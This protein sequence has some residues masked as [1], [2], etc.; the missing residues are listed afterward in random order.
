M[1]VA[2]IAEYLGVTRQRVHQLVPTPGFPAPVTEVVTREWDPAEIEAW[3]ARTWWDTKPWRE[4]PT[5]IH[6][7]RRISSR[8]VRREP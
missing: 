5:T 7:G 6:D 1:N 8:D 2:D 4:R 3:A